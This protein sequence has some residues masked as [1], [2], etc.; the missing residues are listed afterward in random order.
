MI[1]VGSVLCSVGTDFVFP[2]DLE[3]MCNIALTIDSPH[4]LS[5]SRLSQLLLAC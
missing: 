3:H 1:D 2:A 5:D 4:V